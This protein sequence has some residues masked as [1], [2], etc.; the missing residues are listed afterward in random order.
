[1]RVG[2]AA[3]RS[4][5]IVEEAVTDSAGR[6]LIPAGT[7]LTDR[8]LKLIKSWGIVEVGVLEPQDAESPA[9]GDLSEA[10][11]ERVRSRFSEVDLEHPLLSQ[12]LAT[13]LERERGKET[14]S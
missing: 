13:A 3:L 4:G 1:M 14:P 12:L 7:S 9:A 10:L 2:R 5:M 6:V 8:H 11:N